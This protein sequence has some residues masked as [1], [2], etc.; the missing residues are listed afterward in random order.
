M[1]TSS[2]R[3]RLRCTRWPTILLLLALSPCASAQDKPGAAGLAEQLVNN[4]RA[5][6][7]LHEAH[8]HKLSRQDSALGQH[9]FH[10]NRMLAA[11]LVELATGSPASCSELLQK[12]ADEPL[13]KDVDRLALG[14]TVSELALRLPPGNP[15]A[16][17]VDQ[18]RRQLSTV[19]AH[20]DREFTASLGASHGAAPPRPEW[21]AYLAFLRSLPTRPAQPLPEPPSPI[22]DPALRELAGE[23]ERDEWT[24]ADL[25]HLRLLLTF[26]DGPH[27]LHTPRVL[28]IL[29]R[30]GIKA[31]FFQVGQNL[32]TLGADGT[33]ALREP[34]LVRRMLDE[35]HVIA[36]HTY[37][38]ALLPHLDE[39]RLSDE[40]D[41][42]EALLVAAAGD[43]PG[44]GALFR[45]PYGARNDLVLAEVTARGLR[46]VLWNIDSRDWADPIPRSIVTRVVEEAL[47]EGRGIVLLHDIHP[48]TVEALPILLDE[49]LRRGFRFARY[50]EGRLVND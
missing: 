34:S 17:G 22:D 45:P 41:R 37:T 2:R 47:H 20:Y 44:H 36:N 7:L 14:G 48:R 23:G 25:P 26:D 21:S 15:C 29:K 9:L 11:A 12:A 40:I 28:D 10:Q 32:G 19:R 13:W 42:T 33:P 1:E 24:H 38:H 6:I 46:S 5:L 8:P 49:L 16:Q 4:F 18:A 27:P 35:G 31:V 30:Y 43:R 50:A 39:V 3:P